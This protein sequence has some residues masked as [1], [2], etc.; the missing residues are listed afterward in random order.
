MKRIDELR[1]R[2]TN[3]MPFF[4]ASFLRTSVSSRGTSGTTSPGKKC[5]MKGIIALY[6]T[7]GFTKETR[8]VQEG[9][10]GKGLSKGIK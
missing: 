3:S 2:H 5:T 1:G 9:K 8:G 6:K 10:V 7:L 4:A